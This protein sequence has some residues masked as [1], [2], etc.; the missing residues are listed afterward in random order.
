MSPSVQE[1]LELLKL[2]ERPEN[3]SVALQFRNWMGAT[4]PRQDAPQEARLMLAN[5]QNWDTAREIV[6]LLGQTPFRAY[7][8]F[9][10]QVEA[11]L[12]S[13]LK[14]RDDRTEWRVV[15]SLPRKLTS[16]YLSIA[17]RRKHIE[18]GAQV[19]AEDLAR[20]CYFGVHVGQRTAA[21]RPMGAALRHDKFKPSKTYAGYRY[22]RDLGLSA[23]SGLADDLLRINADNHAQAR[24]VAASVAD[25][26]W[27]LFERHA[28]DIEALNFAGT[29]RSR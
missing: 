11:A 14:D 17:P 5:R 21:T 29:R 15:L 20:K 8:V 7:S 26:M 16:T 18:A 25:F 19:C 1:D 9:W 6:A 4:E 28:K 24:P 22:F 27:T 10:E 3:L 23:F 13:R 2:L 12:N